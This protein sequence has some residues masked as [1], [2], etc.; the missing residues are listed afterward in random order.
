MTPVRLLIVTLKPY[1]IIHLHIMKPTKIVVFSGLK[2]C[3]AE[4]SN[5]FEFGSDISSLSLS[6][7]RRTFAR[8]VRSFI[9][10]IGSTRTYSLFRIRNLE[11]FFDKHLTLSDC[12]PVLPFLHV[13]LCTGSSRSTIFNFYVRLR[14]GKNRITVNRPRQT[15]LQFGRT[16]TLGSNKR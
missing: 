2:I 7:W 6:L 5:D 11:E 9:T 3:F 14:A 15:K 13:R 8:N 10:V 12:F 1:I 4:P 16:N